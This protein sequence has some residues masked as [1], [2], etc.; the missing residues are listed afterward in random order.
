MAVDLLFGTDRRVAIFSFIVRFVDGN[1]NF[2]L[3][4]LPLFVAVV[5][6]ARSILRYLLQLLFD[7]FTS[8]ISGPD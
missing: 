6:V 8:A 2:V 7:L 1:F 4:L 3:G 5:V